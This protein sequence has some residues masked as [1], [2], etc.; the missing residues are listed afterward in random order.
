MPPLACDLVHNMSLRGGC[1]SSKSTDKKYGKRKKHDID[2]KKYYT[3][4]CVLL[5]KLNLAIFAAS[6]ITE[7][8]EWFRTKKQITMQMIFQKS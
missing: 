6:I 1:S 2:H 3:K 4:H 8:T 5:Q 7:K